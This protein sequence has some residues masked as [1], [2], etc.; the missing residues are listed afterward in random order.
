MCR[1][2]PI[3]PLAIAMT[4]VDGNHKFAPS[5]IL[6]IVHAGSETAAGATGVAQGID[7]IVEAG[8]KMAG[9]GP[10][11]RDPE[12]VADMMIADPKEVCVADFRRRGDA[13]RS[14]HLV[15]CAHL[16][17]STEG[18]P[19]CL[20][21]DSSC[22]E[23]SQRKWSGKYLWYGEVSLQVRL[24]WELRRFSSK[25]FSF[26]A[27]ADRLLLRVSSSSTT[28]TQVLTQALPWFCVTFFCEWTSCG[29]CA[30]ATNTLRE[31]R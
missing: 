27:N 24:S 26:V 23:M 3:A 20:R 22:T 4:N 12:V 8:H 17:C 1:L 10:E 31:P 7:T 14:Q 21:A 2:L 16:P 11:G 19:K 25:R 30:A 18:K 9:E 6:E 28:T 5:E 15:K 29:R 13:R